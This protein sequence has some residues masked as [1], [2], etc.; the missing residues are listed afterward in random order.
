MPQK[1]WRISPAL[2]PSPRWS[3]SDP[4]RRRVDW[5]DLE[6][7]LYAWAPEHPS[8]LLTPARL[9]EINKLRLS[10]SRLS[11][12]IAHVRRMAD[13]AVGQSPAANAWVTVYGPATNN[14]E[15]ARLALKRIQCCSLIWLLTGEVRYADQ[16]RAEA[17][18]LSILPWGGDFDYLATAEATNALVIGYDWLYH[19]LSVADRASIL[20]GIRRSITNTNRLI[21]GG[22]WWLR[23]PFNANSVMT[24]S[25]ILGAL[26][27][28]DVDKDLSYE[29]L[30]RALPALSLS[31]GS[32]GSDGGWMEGYTYWDFA[33]RYMAYGLGALETTLG[34][35]FGLEAAPG[36]RWAGDYKLI[37]GG[38]RFQAFNFADSITDAS[39]AA[40]MLYFARKYNR[41]EWAEC[42]R[43]SVSVRGP[44]P[45]HVVWYTSAGSES[46]IV[47]RVPSKVFHAGGLAALRAS[48]TDGNAAAA[49]LKAGD[50]G[51][52]HCMQEL[53]NFLF[54]AMGVRWAVDFGYYDAGFRALTSSQNL[55]LFDGRQQAVNVR[56]SFVDFSD[57]SRCPYAVADLS[58]ANPGI[59]S[60]WRRGVALPG[61]RWA[62]V[63][64][65][66]LATPG[67]LVQWKMHTFAEVETFGCVARLT[68]AGKSATLIVS[69]PPG[70]IIEVA[71]VGDRATT[72]AD[73]NANEVQFR[74]RAD[75]TLQTVRVLLLPEWPDQIPPAGWMCLPLDQW[76]ALYR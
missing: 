68:Q 59:V 48:L 42:E 66:F 74:F 60:F 11:S 28:A 13:E 8:I 6:A 76:S 5:E 40:Q 67:T 65:E 58:S 25:A 75:G 2:P 55:L 30:R 36:L 69:D 1:P 12:W 3:P 44:W 21:D 20:D 29:T 73:A 39:P 62:M 50:N 34:T 72:P 14:I 26:A 19:R 43:R 10:D 22:A 23:K 27:Y 45:M 38:P 4:F 7:T 17:L 70:A 18:A 57:D 63:Q 35:T 52:V 64:D 71:R 47:A 51:N 15:V 41:P 61:G 33:T 37:V 31:I 49:A 46:D 32:L 54:E 16:A 24:A 9:E 56:A 53:G